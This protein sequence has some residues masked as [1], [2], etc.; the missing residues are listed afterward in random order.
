[1]AYLYANCNGMFTKDSWIEVCDEFIKGIK[2]FQTQYIQ[3]CNKSG[4]ILK[5]EKIY[6]PTSEN[7]DPTSENSDPIAEN[8]MVVI[9]ANKDYIIFSVLINCM[10]RKENTND[11]D[12]EPIVIVLMRTGTANK[13]CKAEVSEQM[14]ITFQIMEREDKGFIT[15][16]PDYELLE[17]N[18]YETIRTILVRRH[19]EL[20]RIESIELIMMH[21]K[22][23]ECVQS[24]LDNSNSNVCGE[25]LNRIET[26]VDNLMRIRM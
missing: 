3:I 2:K 19:L 22:A 12:N 6:S 21:K 23:V 26:S 15:L 8:I 14:S 1:M 4:K 10:V 13:D 5:L 24:Y 7:R 17:S 25:I 18:L 20:K 16:N 9:K 11:S